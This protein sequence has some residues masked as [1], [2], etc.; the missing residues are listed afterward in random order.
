MFIAVAAAGMNVGSKG[1]DDRNL[2]FASIPMPNP[3]T[4]QRTLDQWHAPANQ[5]PTTEHHP[6]VAKGH[7]ASSPSTSITKLS[8]ILL[9]RSGIICHGI[10]NWLELVT[11]LPCD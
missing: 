5:Q 3:L 11:A 7:G 4:V 8:R 2:P 10:L 9:P 6:L 1:Y